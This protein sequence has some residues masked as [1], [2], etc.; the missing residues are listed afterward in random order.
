M[1]VQACISDLFNTLKREKG[2]VGIKSVRGRAFSFFVL[3]FVLDGLY[4]EVL[5]E[6]VRHDH[7]LF[8]RFACGAAR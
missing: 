5:D 1:A 3:L 2:F 8:A 6:A 7:R 4:I